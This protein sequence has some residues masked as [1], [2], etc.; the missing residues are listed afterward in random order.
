MVGV[1]VSWTSWASTSPDE[2]AKYIYIWIANCWL[3]PRKGPVVVLWTENM[4][5]ALNC[6]QRN[7]VN[8]SK[9]S[10]GTISYWRQYLRK[11]FAY[12]SKSV[13]GLHL[14]AGTLNQGGHATDNIAT[15]KLAVQSQ[16]T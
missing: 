16:N 6:H 13:G 14:T 10:I 4:H 8:P 12:P 2:L 1:C 15:K 3:E 7:S 9:E 11:A 5:Y